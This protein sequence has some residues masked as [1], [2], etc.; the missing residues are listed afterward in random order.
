[1]LCYTGNKSKSRTKLVPRHRCTSNS[2]QLSVESN[3]TSQLSQVNVNNNSQA[4]NVSISIQSSINHANQ[5]NSV[6]SNQQLLYKLPERPRGGSVV[7][8]LTFMKYDPSDG[9][10]QRTDA[11]GR[12]LG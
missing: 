10:C 4:L 2:D 3:N 5:I 8:S 9:S 7:Q 11:F 6:K 12:S 1:M